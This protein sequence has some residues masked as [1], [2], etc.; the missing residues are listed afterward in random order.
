MFRILGSTAI[1]V[2]ALQTSVFSQAPDNTNVNRRDRNSGTATADQQN[3][4]RSDVEITREIS[5]AQSY[6]IR[7][8]PRTP[9]T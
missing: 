3:G 5:D 2:F 8:S 6:K 9:R 4:N 7:R 1:F